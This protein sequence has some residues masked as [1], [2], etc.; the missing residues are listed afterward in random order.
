[1]LTAKVSWFLQSR[2]DE[3]QSRNQIEDAKLGA[4]DF[5]RKALDVLIA[6]EYVTELEGPRG[7]RLHRL[8]RPF[9]EEAAS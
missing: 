4:R 8:E 7:A 1:V 2:Q 5:V 9:T 3:P 6:E